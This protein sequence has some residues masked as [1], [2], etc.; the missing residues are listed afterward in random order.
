MTGLDASAPK[1][2]REKAH[3]LRNASL[4]KSRTSLPNF[5]ILMHE[6]PSKGLEILNF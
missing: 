4:F 2:A 5:E 3:L 1:I 6:Y